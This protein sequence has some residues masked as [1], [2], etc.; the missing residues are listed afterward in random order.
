[1]SRFSQLI[2]EVADEK[3]HTLQSVLM[4]AKVLAHSLKGKKFRR[5]VE[6]ELNGYPTPDVPPYRVVRAH[7]FGNF[8]GSHLIR[9]VPLSTLSLPSDIREFFETSKFRDGIAYIADLVTAQSET[10]ETIGQNLDFTFVQYLRQRGVCISGHV[11]NEARLVIARQSLVALLDGVRSR[12]LDFLLELRD[13]HPNLDSDDEAPSKLNA[14]E[15][16]EVVERRVYSGCTVIEGGTMGDVYQAGQ[17]G[18]LGPGAKADNNQFIQV[19][20]DS[21]KDASLA[22]LAKE[23]EWLRQSM[24]AESTNADQD[25]AVA[26]IANAEESAKRADAKGVMTHLKNAGKWS[27]DVATKIGTAVAAKAIEKAI[28]G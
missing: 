23:L 5:W 11:L 2:D 24:L 26:E 7:L 20:R 13:K 18:A 12:L 15:V 10:N 22:D 8:A 9:D 16:D 28:M 3:K 21:I 25:Q 27:L 1:M 19:L 4:K 17:A 14:T 6:A